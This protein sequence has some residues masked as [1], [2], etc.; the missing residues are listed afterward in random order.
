MTP[1]DEPGIDPA[2]R[3]RG[4]PETRPYYRTLTE[5]ERQVL[6]SRQGDIE[7]DLRMDYDPYA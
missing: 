3:L 7:R 4:L 5:F 6:D 1:T 2:F